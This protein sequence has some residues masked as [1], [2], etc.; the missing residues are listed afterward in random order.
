MVDIALA[1]SVMIVRVLGLPHTV[2]LLFSE[3]IGKVLLLIIAQTSANIDR[4]PVISMGHFEPGLCK[5]LYYFIERVAK[6]VPG[7]ERV[8]PPMYRPP[9]HCS[10]G[11]TEDI[12]RWS[13]E[14]RPEP[15][16]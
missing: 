13:G 9:E 7:V 1:C 15:A 16:P 11:T 3:F 8:P 6:V 10:V 14:A 2:Y 5:P 12:S 4:L